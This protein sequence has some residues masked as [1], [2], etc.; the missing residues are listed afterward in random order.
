MEIP[1]SYS[2]LPQVRKVCQKA[3]GDC[4]KFAKNGLTVIQICG[5]I[6]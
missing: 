2:A 6:K 3:T 5:R 1:P 4:R